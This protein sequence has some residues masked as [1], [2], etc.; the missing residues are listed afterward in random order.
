MSLC[1]QRSKYCSVGCIQ[2]QGFTFKFVV[3]VN[4]LFIK[5]LQLSGFDSTFFYF[6]VMLLLSDLRR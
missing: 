5:P 6:P 1:Y 4:T 2:E 3:D